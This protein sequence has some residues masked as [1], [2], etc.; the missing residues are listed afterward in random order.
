MTCVRLM[1]ERIFQWEPKMTTSPHVNILELANCSLL[2][3]QGEAIKMGSLWQS[4]TVLFIFL[5]HFACIACRAHAA[6]VWQKRDLYQKGN[7][8]IVFIGNGQPQYIKAFREDLNILEA[9]LFTDPSLKSFHAA[10]F[11]RGFF[12]A[13]GP[14]GIV[15][16]LKLWAEGHEQGSYKKGM[17][18]LWQLGGILVMKPD[19]KVAYH[20]IS[21]STGDFPTED[22]IR[23]TPWISKE[24]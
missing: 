22:D 2:D 21:E 4:Q 8:K 17:G 5:R 23:A 18:D 7:T 16:G 15:N 9:P 11:Q 14:R 20:Y 12:R 1:F 10:G 6:E 3:E 19:S 24:K 13:L